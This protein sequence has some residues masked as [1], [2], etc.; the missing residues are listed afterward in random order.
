MD[1]DTKRAPFNLGDHVRYI[2]A[3]TRELAAG[4]RNKPE[5]VL[6]PGMVGVVMISTA[7]LSG[8]GSSAPNSWRC[9]IQFQNG[10]QLDIGPGNHTDFAMTCGEA[11]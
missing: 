7:A 5:R 1:Q 6:A 10:F 9:R 3:Q 8:Q 11:A 4:R 2:G